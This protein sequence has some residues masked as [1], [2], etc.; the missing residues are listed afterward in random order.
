M[1]F[2][3]G[4]LES[5]DIAMSM[6]PEERLNSTEWLEELFAGLNPYMVGE[7]EQSSFNWRKVWVA[8]LVLA[9][10]VILVVLVCTV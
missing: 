6:D 9:L 2:A 5:V 10:L 4:L 7:T 3:Q 1:S 8:G